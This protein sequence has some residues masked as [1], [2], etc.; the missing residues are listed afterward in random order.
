MSAV[1]PAGVSGTKARTC[2]ASRVSVSSRPPPPVHAIAC[3]AW[4]RRFSVKVCPSWILPKA[5]ASKAFA[6][7]L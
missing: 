7:S 5:P 4:C 3:K 2:R 6:V 1:L